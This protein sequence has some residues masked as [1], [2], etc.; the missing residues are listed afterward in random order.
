MTQL[1]AWA[2][3]EG[4][5]VIEA[6]DGG[7]T[8]QQVLRGHPD[9]VIIPDYTEQVEGVDIL[10]LIRRLTSS[11]IIVVGEGEPAR[12]AKALFDGAD[13]YIKSPKD[14]L[15]FKSRLRFLLRRSGE[16]RQTD[17]GHG[18]TPR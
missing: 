16:R 8:L 3:E 10:P 18:L 7:E 6:Y 4:Y 12:L 13:D 11:A 17:G 15:D 2:A 1:V 14:A 5:R 9:V